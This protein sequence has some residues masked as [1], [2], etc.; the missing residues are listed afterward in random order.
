VNRL[1]LNSLTRAQLSQLRTIS[2]RISRA[3]HDEGEWQPTPE[4]S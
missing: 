3:I 4:G 1:V 2:G